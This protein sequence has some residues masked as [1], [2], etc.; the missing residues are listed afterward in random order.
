PLIAPPKSRTAIHTTTTSRRWSW[1][2]PPKRPKS[3]ALAGFPMGVVMSELIAWSFRGGPGVRRLEDA[4]LIGAGA[5]AADVPTGRASTFAPTITGWT[6]HLVRPRTP[7]PGGC[8]HVVTGFGCGGRRRVERSVNRRA[9]VF[10]C[11]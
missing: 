3:G 11:A 4:E 9:L 10:L 1:H 2:H 7:L 8:G 5:R 6:A